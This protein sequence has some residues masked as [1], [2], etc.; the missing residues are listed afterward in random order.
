MTAFEEAR[1]IILEEI[2][3]LDAEQVQLL[4]SLGRVLAEDVMAPWSLPSFSN[5]AMDGYA[6]RAEDC[7]DG[8]V[9]PIID[10]IPAGG[11]AT[12]DVTPGTAIKIMTGAPVPEG[13]DSIVPL[14]DANESDGSLRVVKPVKLHQHIRLA[15]EDVGKGETVLVAGT[16]VRPYEINMLAS[17]GKKQ[18]AVVRRPRVAVVATGDELVEL[19]TVPLPGQIVNSNA[20]SMVAAITSVGAVPV[21]VGIARDTLESTREKLTEGLNAD[22]LITSAGVSVGDRDLVREVLES[23]GVEIVFWR[24]KVKPGKSMAFG[25]KDGKFV[26][27]LPGNPVSGMLTFEEFVAPALL[28]MMGHRKTLKPLFPAVLQGALKKKAGQIHLV[29]VRLEYIDGK[30]LAWSAGKQDSGRM[31]TL[32]QAN[33]LAVLPEDRDSFAT[34]EEIQ[35]HLLDETV[36]MTTA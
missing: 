15:G 30:Y 26:F 22:V 27:A 10:Y 20:Y 5:S 17:F 4:E 36:G 35:V 34:G 9:L 11:H 28:K 1:R 24:V 33:G 7:R 13:C 12:K 2:T 3:P 8:R 21:M 16:V 31:K 29:R 23:L 25:R 32:L 19:G 6:V 18:V 14:E